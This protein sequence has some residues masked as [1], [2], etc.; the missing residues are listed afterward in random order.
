MYANHREW[1][2]SAL[3]RRT[4]RVL[5]S[6]MGDLRRVTASLALPVT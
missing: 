3:T 2:A 1:S 6:F 5:Y 4:P